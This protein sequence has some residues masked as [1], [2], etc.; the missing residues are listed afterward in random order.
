MPELR[1]DPVIGYWTI[2]STERSRRPLSITPK[3]QAPAAQ[4][5]FCEGR[6]SQTT[7]ELFA[8]RSPGSPANGPGWNVRVFTA[9]N[10]LLESDSQIDRYGEGVYDVMEGAGRHEVIVETPR[11]DTDIDSL[12]IAEIEGVLSAYVARFNALAEDHRFKYALLFK[13]HGVTTGAPSQVLRH[14]RSQI[15]AMPIVPKRVKEELASAKSY[16]DRRDRCVYCDILRQESRSGQRTVAENEDF[17][18]FCPFAAR[19]PFET[20]VFP[21]T[22]SA[23]F[24]RLQSSDLGSLARI[25]KQC[26]GK[27]RVLLDDPPY[28]LILHTAPYR[29]KK[30]ETSWKTIEEDYHWYL[31]ISP[32]LTRSAGFEWGTGIHINPTPAEDAAQLLRET[33]SE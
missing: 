19:S 25:L 23:D 4:C 11:H 33:P 21:K 1:R 2:V 20:W 17:Y 9:K 28:N 30:R 8:L 12:S 15:I 5:P 18:A 27:L 14:S 32:R 26:L 13:N 24:G 31:Q 7:P 3:P 10:P 6:E 29:H 16:F 22:H